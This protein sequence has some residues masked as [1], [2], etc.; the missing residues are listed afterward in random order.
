[1]AIKSSEV[2]DNVEGARSRRALFRQLEDSG[3]DIRLLTIHLLPGADA[4]RTA[5]WLLDRGLWPIPISAPDDP[6]ASHPGISPIG[7]RCWCR[8]PTV[9]KLRA[10]YRWHPKG[11][12]GI[13]L[14]PRG[15]VV[16]LKVNDVVRADP[17][18]QKL[19][20]SGLPAT[21][22]WK[23]A[24]SEHRLYA[25]D[26]RLAGLALSALEKHS[27]GALELRLGAAETQ[28]VSVCPPSIRADDVPRVWNGIWKIAPFP[29]ELVG[30][31]ERSGRDGASHPAPGNRTV[32]PT[33]GSVEPSAGAE[34]AREIEID[35][36]LRRTPEIGEHRPRTSPAENHERTS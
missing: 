1:M 23:S 7:G 21:L 8:R 33:R 3:V 11:G 30:A 20:P 9:E 24:G 31:L 12:V 27:D 2:D 22:G 5:V 4:L 29:E 18:L 26:G 32:D 16:D 17:I 25:W 6:R 14:G 15:K 36:M 34:L 10:V 19:S 13:L 28:V 35:S